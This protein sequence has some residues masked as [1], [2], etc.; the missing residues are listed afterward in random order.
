MNDIVKLRAEVDELDKQMNAIIERR[1]RA[2]ADL[3]SQCRHQGP[4][5][6]DR[7]NPYGD[8][9]AYH[10][11]MRACVFCGLQENQPIADPGDEYDFATYGSYKT[12]TGPTYE[13]T[14][15]EVWK[16]IRSKR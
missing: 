4:I 3:Q 12:L 7:G 5:V 10:G 2:L 1:N 16:T 14:R 8:R 9:W 13:V 6:E 11:G 15:E